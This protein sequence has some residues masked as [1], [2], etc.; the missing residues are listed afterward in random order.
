MTQISESGATQF[1]PMIQSLGKGDE[2]SLD[3]AAA[4][5]LKEFQMTVIVAE[6]LRPLLIRG[7]SE[8]EVK[9]MLLEG[10][11]N[12]FPEFEKLLKSVQ[13]SIDRTDFTQTRILSNHEDKIRRAL[14]DKAIAKANN[15]RIPCRDFERWS[16]EELKEYI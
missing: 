15:E 16:N 2:R 8:G 6:H 3:A 12:T 13:E 9:L 10:L 1:L 11:R 4:S 14:I 5:R 7:S